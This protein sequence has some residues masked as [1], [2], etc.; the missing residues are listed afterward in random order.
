ME[1]AVVPIPNMRAFSED[2]ALAWLRD[3]G[4]VQQSNAALARAWGWNATKVSR[5]L[6]AWSK[7]GLI[8]RVRNGIIVARPSAP[9]RLGAP[10]EPPL[11]E[12]PAAA[13][14]PAVLTPPHAVRTSALPPVVVRLAAP[15]LAAAALALGG[16]GLVLNARFAASF[17]QSH[18]AAWLLASIGVAIDL[19]AILLPVAACQLWRQRYFVSAVAAW[20]VWLIA[21]TITLP[22]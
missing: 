5:R 7:A 1:A 8:E 6:T 16:V 20:S 22:P 14:G 13:G 10:A 11:A 12:T 17:G 18:D 15:L 19:I 21:L 2:E 9:A 4:P 3:N